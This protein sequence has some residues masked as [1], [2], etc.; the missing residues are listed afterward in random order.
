R[1]NLNQHAALL[2]QLK[3][4]NMSGDETDG[5][6]KTHLPTWSIVISDWQSLPL[7]TML[8]R[9]DEMGIEDWLHPKGTRATQG[10]PPRLR[11]L[12]D[13]GKTEDGNAPSGLH[14]NCYNPAWLD[15]LC[16]HQ[17]R[18]LQMIDTDYDF[19]I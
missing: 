16:P 12:R 5:P 9:I 1:R 6:S 15:T 8:W 18:N 10:N 13:G 19:S 4:R 3:P 7:R 2:K 17:L 11:I 14:R